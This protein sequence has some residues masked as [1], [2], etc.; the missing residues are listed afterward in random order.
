MLIFMGYLLLALGRL[1]QVDHKFE[2]RLGYTVRPCLKRE[3]E[4]ERATA[5]EEEEEEKE[6]EEEEKKEG[7]ER[8]IL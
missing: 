5:S 7:E 8:E 6:E 1:R 4:E 2:A 3:R